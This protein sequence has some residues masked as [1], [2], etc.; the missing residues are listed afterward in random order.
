MSPRETAWQ[1]ARERIAAAA[2][3]AGRAPSDVALLAVSKTVAPDAVRAVHALGQRAF[4][5]NYVQEAVAKREALADLPDLRWHLIGPLQANKTRVA[6]TTFDCVETVDR[7]RI[8]TR[9]AEARD[10]ARGPLDVLVQVN[11]SGEV[12]KSGVSAP[13]AVDLARAMASLPGLR[14]RGI[15]GIPEPTE[16]TLRLRAQFDLLREAFEACRAAGL[17]VDTLSMG[18]SGDLEMAIAAGATEVR[19]GTAIFGPRPA[20]LEP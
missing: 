9:L 14:L 1:A 19:V 6:A 11:A 3:A 17:A 15:M 5:E 16:D 12:T 2:R 10:P 13:E 7:V 8:A 20:R 4:G 18:M